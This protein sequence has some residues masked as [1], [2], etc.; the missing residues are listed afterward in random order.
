MRAQYTIESILASCAIGSDKRAHLDSVIEHRRLV[1]ASMER[2]KR[3]GTT[4]RP[5]TDS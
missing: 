5:R 2:L 1:L 3:P 4:I